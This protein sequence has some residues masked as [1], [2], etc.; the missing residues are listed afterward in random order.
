MDGILTGTT[1]LI[2]NGPGRNEGVLHTP[3]SSRIGGGVLI[4]C[5][6]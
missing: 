3:K 2:Q 4:V 5:N 1:T 6:G